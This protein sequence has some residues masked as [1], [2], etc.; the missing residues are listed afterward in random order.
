MC[1]RT[2]QAKMRYPSWAWLVSELGYLAQWPSN[3]AQCLHFEE[4]R[5]A[6]TSGLTAMV[7]N[8]VCH[9]CMSSL[10]LTDRFGDRS[11]SALAAI[12]DWD[13]ADGWIALIENGGKHEFQ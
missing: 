4:C 2:N 12:W 7:S 10:N 5:P 6:F 8:R 3:S 9:A 1:P 11:F 13:Y